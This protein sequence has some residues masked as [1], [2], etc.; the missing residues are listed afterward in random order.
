MIYP[1][2]DKETLRWHVR[3]HNKSK[4]PQKIEQKISSN[5]T[6]CQVSLDI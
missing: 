2:L 5:V 6:K 1:W 4:T 3:K